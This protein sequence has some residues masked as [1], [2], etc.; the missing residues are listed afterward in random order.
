MTATRDDFEHWLF[1]MDDHL[2]KFIDILPT[3]ISSKLDYSTGSL[4]F[5]EGWLLSKYGSVNEILKES[6][7][8]TLDMVARYVGETFRKNLGGIWNID[9]KNKK[10]VFYRMPVIEKLGSWTQCPITL[11]TA[12][13]DR[14]SGSFMTGVLNS[15]ASRYGAV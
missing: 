15:I 6:E 2:K 7:K 10:N 4:S 11:V 3:D 8:Q 12:S 1:E 13:L 9:L 14:R 5:L